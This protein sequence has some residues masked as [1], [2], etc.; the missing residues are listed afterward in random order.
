[1]KT[2]LRYL[3]LNAQAAWNRLVQEHL[4]L[5]QKLTNIESAQVVLER[6]REDT[7]AFRAHVV[8]VVPGPDFH[9]DAAD[10]TLTAALHKVIKNLR[11]QILA[12][13]TNHRV[14]GKSN[15]QL[16]TMSRR[17]PS[18]PAGLRA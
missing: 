7:P 3:G 5:L 2:S 18:A 9:A 17:W 12:R 4:N 11:R 16:G 1:M 13:Q 6:Q 15:Q 10:Y 8:L 14:K